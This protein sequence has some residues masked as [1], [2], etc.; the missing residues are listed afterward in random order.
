M[1]LS[2]ITLFTFVT[3]ALNAQLDVTVSPP[4][5]IE[6]KTI[7]PLAITNHLGEK[8]ESA[9]ALC[10]LLDEQGKM[11]GESAKWVIG[12]TKDRPA[13]EPKAGTTFNFVMT[14]P[15]R[16]TTT[17]LTAKVSFTQLVLASGQAANPNKDVIIEAAQRK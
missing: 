10:F 17:N 11:I 5:I 9:R 7:I 8:V 12:G 6:Q 16:F 4:K 2:A 3:L 15:Q 1:K 14:N 13:L